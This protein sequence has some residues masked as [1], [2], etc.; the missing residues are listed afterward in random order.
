MANY[1]HPATERAIE[2]FRKVADAMEHGDAHLRLE[3]FSTDGPLMVQSFVV[4]L[5]GI[6]TA[7]VIDA[8]RLDAAVDVR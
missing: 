5:D 8:R 6:V 4:V 3:H 7:L 2:T 1:G